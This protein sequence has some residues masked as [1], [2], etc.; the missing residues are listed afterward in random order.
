MG[1]RRLYRTK[2]PFD[3]YPFE[4]LCC[5]S[6]KAVELIRI[7]D[8]SMTMQFVDSQYVIEE[9]GPFSNLRIRSRKANLSD[10]TC[11]L[12]PG[13]DVCVLSTSQH[14]GSSGEDNLEPVW[15]DA[16][17]SSIERKPHESRCACQFYINF[18]VNPGPLGSEKGTLSK[19]ITIV[20][21]DKISILQRLE[22]S[23]C[24]D[25]HY[26]WNS[27]ED[28]SSVRKTKLFLGKFLSELSWLLVASV[29]KQIVFDV[30]SVRN[31]IVYQILGGDRDRCSLNSDKHSNAINFRADGELLIPIVVPFVLTDIHEASPGC[32]VREV[33]P[34]S[35]YDLMDLRRSKRR[36]VQ[37][38]RFV[39]CDG[40]SE[41]DIGSFRT[42]LYKIDKWK[43]DDMSLTLSDLFGIHASF[44]EKRTE[45]E[46]RVNSCKI[47]ACEDLIVSK[48]K[49][50]LREVK[51]CIANRREHQNQLAIIP[52]PDEHDPIACEQDDFNADYFGNHSGGIGENSSKYY[53]INASPTMQ[54]K[55]TSEGEYLE[56][57]SRREGNGSSNNGRRRR[58]YSLHLERDSFCESRGQGRKSLSASGYNEVI[59]TYIKNINSTIKKEEPL[60]I[61]QWRDFQATNCLNQR[62]DCNETSSNED[63]EESSETEMLW[64][65]MELSIASSYLLED[66]EGSNVE[67]P[68]KVV[69]K[70]SEGGKFC[71]HKYKLDEE[72]G[73]LCQ[74]CGFVSTE[75]KDVSPPFV[76]YTSW[77][78]NNKLYSDEDSENKETEDE[79]L[80]LFCDRASSETP[81]SLSEGNENV[82]ALIPDLRKKLHFHQK[83]AFEFLWRNIAGSL[84]PDLMDPAFK[85]RGG[86]VISHSPGAGKTLLVI[87]F[88]ASYMKLFPGKRPLVLAPKTTLCTWYKE[89][90]KWELKIPVHQIHNGRTYRMFRQKAIVPPGAPKPGQD[91]MHVLDCL[92]KIRKWHAEPSV[93]IM[94]YTSFLAMM[95]EDSKFAH[96]RYMGEVLRKSPGILIL[97]E[98][99]NPRSTKSRLR[100]ALMKV[101][102]DLRI[103]LSGTLFQNNFGEYFNTLSLAR[104][105]FVDEV[106]KELDPKFRRKKK[107][108]KK[109]RCLIENRARKFFI[110]KIGN[111][112][113]SSIAEDRIRG[114]NML[115]NLTNGFID[116]YE[117]GNSDNLPGLQSYTLM[118]KSTSIQH[119]IL[120]KLQKERAEYKRFPLELELLITLGSIHPWLIT[121]AACANK[122]FSM[123][124]LMEFG[125]HKLDFKKG[126]KVKFIVSLVN[127]CIIKG[128][129]IL[130]FCHNIAPINY[131]LNMFEIL[132]GWRKGKQVLVLQGDLELFERGRVMDKFEEPGGASRVL[133]ASITACAEGVSLTAASRVVL[134]DSEWNPSKTKQAIARAFRPGQQRVVYVYQ[135]LARNTLE[136]EKYDRTT[137]KEW[138]SSMIFSEELV[139]DPSRWQKEKIEDDVL[140]EIVEEDWAKSFYMIMKNEKAS[141]GC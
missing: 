40:L 64:R 14:T 4:A 2:H 81:L 59:K 74:L 122:Y 41:S 98:G 42:G 114:L 49:I 38:E 120:D 86:C 126:S 85:N 75:I 16:K 28:C 52:L 135:L 29:L 115:R 25:D 97:D 60:V 34:S 141:M 76:H 45:G 39:G 77:I 26:R 71:Q 17:I 65:E 8:G 87:A 15:V 36:Y 84:V 123:Q 108:V 131:F 37:P 138:V 5:D 70:S 58:S 68:T 56:F 91:V 133:L 116:V 102:T 67:V 11:F 47:D 46:K 27:S 7:K 80:D 79:S 137:W 43:D 63:A 89:I 90:I 125:K 106:L 112:I 20:E 54:R 13:I 140:R 118:M 66:N 110:E 103:L 3:A 117:N 127:H 62:R 50:N 51:S 113:N 9:K 21:I 111:K 53:Y 109:P 88:L 132:Y 83:K 6:W 101:E 1:K 55:N 139:E 32:D 130:I 128:E 78:T 105:K 48:N 134:L 82:W 31:K 10:C 23:P 136:Q 107:G 44:S 124:E 24:E 96:R 61:E 119:E 18:Y 33:G 73:V 57:E 35:F 22:R 94:G 93:L 95:R 99:H 12:R 129:K 69:Q 19:E 72:I 100:K 104:P 30:R 121:T 92:E